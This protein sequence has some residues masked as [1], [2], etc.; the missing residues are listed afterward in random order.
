MGEKLMLN[1]GRWWW[2]LI[3]LGV[4][5]LLIGCAKGAS[6]N[7]DNESNEDVEPVT[8]KFAA[9]M[10]WI[11]EEEFQEYFVDPVS[12]RYPYITLEPID[13]GD[14]DNSWEELFA[15]N[16]I[17]DIVMTASPIIDRFTEQDLE[18]DIEQLIE[19]NSFDLSKLNSVV[20]DSVKSASQSEYLTG[21]PWT[22]HFH[23]IYYNKDI[24]DRFGVD[25][26]SDGLT[27]DELREVA[28]QLTVDEGDVQ[29]RGLEP[30]QPAIMGGQLGLTLLDPETMEATIDTEDWRKV[31][32][33]LESIYGIPGNGNPT[34]ADGAFRMFSEDRTLAMFTSNNILPHLESIDDLN[35]DIA[36]YPAFPEQPNVAAEVDAWILHITKQSEHKQAAFEVIETVL[37]EEV[38][39]KIAKNGR[40]PI[41]ET[42]KVLD[43]FGENLPHVEGKNL[44]AVFKSDPAPALPVVKNSRDNDVGLLRDSIIDVVN[45]EID[46]NTALREAQ[47]ELEAMI[48][49]YLGNE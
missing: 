6:N 27:W 11:T 47:E 25:Y 24:F 1:T 37:S 9:S 17:P 36:Q 48:E 16:I 21:L 26:L 8:I 4:M 18:Y 14:P 43:A 41:M 45:G 22:M 3:S 32:Q 33:M 40:T 38:Q 29:Y 12:E 28:R 7:E 20:V 39:T 34:F 23:A 15:A 46:I 13:I 31:F 42:S 2:I 30:D 49:D 44:E 19:E 10:G 35:W 5:L